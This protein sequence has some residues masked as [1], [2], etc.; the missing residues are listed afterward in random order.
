MASHLLRSTAARMRRAFNG[1]GSHVLATSSPDLKQSR[2]PL[3]SVVFPIYNVEHYVAV[4]LRSLLDQEYSDIEVI[5]V[6]DG[7][8]DG[9]AAIVRRIAQDDS[10]VRLIQQANGGLSAARNTGIE[11]AKGDYLAFVDS[12]DVVEQSGF[13]RMVE[14]L[15]ITGSDF[16]VGS[17]QHLTGGKTVRPGVWIRQVHDH[18]RLQTSLEDF[19]AC[20][21]NAVIWSKVFRRSF[22]DNSGLTFPV[23]VLYEDQ[24]ISTAAY[25]LAESFDIVKDSVIQWRI[26]ETGQSITQQASAPENLSSRFDSAIRSLTVLQRY[27]RFDVREIRALQYLANNTFTLW[28][29]A[30]GDRKYF[31]I[32]R[33]RL[34]EIFSMTSISKIRDQ[35]SVYDKALYHLIL[36]DQFDEAVMAVRKRLRN[37]GTWH[38]TV[39]DGV[40]QG[41]WPVSPE[42]LSQA[43]VWVT[44]FTER[45]TQLQSILTGLTW[46]GSE[47]LI[48][49][50]NMYL[51]NM[52][53]PTEAVARQLALVSESAGFTTSVPLRH[54]TD[55]KAIE[56]SG[57]ENIDFSNTGFEAE[58][59]VPALRAQLQGIAAEKARLYLYGQVD[60]A[61]VHRGGRILKRLRSTGMR[62]LIERFV[63]DWTV[64]TCS[65]DDDLGLMLS[66]VHVRAVLRW[67][68]YSDQTLTIEIDLADAKTLPSRIDIIGD[69]MEGKPRVRI[70]GM[71]QPVQD[72]QSS[73]MTATFIF[74]VEVLKQSS[75]WSVAVYYGASRE[76]LRQRD[77]SVGIISDSPDLMTVPTAKLR[78]TVQNARS[79]IVVVGADGADGQLFLDVV[80]NGMPPVSLAAA[81]VRGGRKITAHV[82][83]GNDNGARLIFPLV[84]KARED[85][86]AIAPPSGIYSVEATD[87]DRPHHTLATRMGDTVGALDSIQVNSERWQARI[88][89]GGYLKPIISINPP[90]G[91]ER[92]G[93]LIRRDLRA[94]YASARPKLTKTVYMQCLRGDQVADTQL[95]L[96]EEIARSG[97]D[98]S[99]VWGIKDYSVS[100]PERDSA[101][102][103]GSPEYFEVLAS[104]QYVCVNHELTP[105]FDKKPGQVVIQTYHGHPFKSMGMHRWNSRGFSQPQIDR[106]LAS[107]KDWDI[108]LSPSPIATQLYRENF[109][110]PYQIAE[111]GHPRNDRLI[112]VTENER[113]MLRRSLGIPE[114]AKAV[115]YAPTWRELMTNDPWAA[116]IVTFIDPVEL[117]GALGQN[118]VVLLRGHPANGRFDASSHAAE[119]VIDVTFWPDVNDLIIASDIGVFDYSSIRFDYAVT[120]KP[121]VFL[122]PDKEQYFSF[123]PALIDFD[124]TAPG[125]Q[126]ADLDELVFAIQEA[127]QGGNYYY[128][129]EYDDFNSRFTPLDDGLAAGRLLANML[130]FKAR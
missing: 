72:G 96:S 32:L 27:G 68:S 42:L 116:P 47:R 25:C 54:L 106:S 33:D 31:E 128:Q 91:W 79:E 111:V 41:E 8:T 97:E 15:Q 103:V 20:L 61:G 48:L 45:D 6:D 76:L 94:S 14:T 35:V 18:D 93:G 92:S 109:P 117:S 39:H 88:G 24:E 51:A 90:G 58:I 23:G 38:G 105:E 101:V 53:V 57:Q 127:S 40:P 126:V 122:V 69:R 9:S 120:R 30:D 83:Q 71:I 34:G 49:R 73:R 28:H 17:Y 10:R 123:T 80:F 19:S 37:L 60:A 129:S 100:F 110:L 1:D 119:G 55:A 22:W 86:S 89:V 113:A 56:R 12:D 124:E 7:S 44:E 130:A 74:P 121:M 16:A 3:L 65:W 4:S 81:L 66:F 108:L 107:R 43:P 84:E 46:E 29:L 13:A 62:S 98:L 63:D 95:A 77:M 99:V 102:I 78:V 59:D 52:D 11:H 87:Q 118:T 26:R 85:W 112:R 115:L 2:A 114:G 64:L 36:N 82:E 125:A 5:A 70:R 104:A 21:A 67:I 75:R 50:G